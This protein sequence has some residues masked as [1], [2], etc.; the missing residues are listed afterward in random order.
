MEAL[1]VTCFDV[2]TR[3]E[4][5]G[6]HRVAFVGTAKNAGKT[7]ALNHFLSS[8][9]VRGEAAGL[10]SVGVDGEANDALSGLAKPRIF[11]PEGTLIASAARALESSTAKFEWLE[12]LR[13]SSPLGPIMIARV[14]TPG[15][16][17]LAGVRQRQHVA[18]VLPR[19]QHWGAVWCLVDGAFDRVAAAAPQLVDAVILAV[20]PAG[21]VT[22]PVGSVGPA[23]VAR[24]S[25]VAAVTAAARPFLLRYQLPAVNDQVREQLAAAMNAGVI[26]WVS[27]VDTGVTETVVGHASGSGGQAPA[28]QALFGLRRHPDWSARVAAVYLP[29]VITDEILDDL[30]AHPRPLQLIAAHPAQVLVSAAAWA[31]FERIGHRIAVWHAVPLAAVAINPTHVSGRWLDAAALAGSI[32]GLAGNVPVYNPMADFETDACGHAG[33]ETCG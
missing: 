19:L 23:A 12:E 25:A 1:S 21:A 33:G 6:W 4:A 3:C 24:T 26:G 13:I 17:L 16:V 14:T 32:Q 28:A 27:T 5:A 8:V 9:N 31:R 29:G 22:G 30:A 10:C 2:V 11:A 20:G 18:A 15:Y 7:T